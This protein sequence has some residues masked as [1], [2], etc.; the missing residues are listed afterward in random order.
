V[1]AKLTA[2]V[3]A[4]DRGESPAGDR[5]TVARFLD[6]WLAASASSLRPRTL[7]GYASHVAIYIK[8]MLGATPLAKLTPGH[9]QTML[10]ELERHGRPGNVER[11]PLSAQTVAHVRA[12]LRRALGQ[13]ERW[14][15]VTRNV[16]KLTDAPR[17]RRVDVHPLAGVE[18]R[19]FLDATRED[20]VWPLYVVAIATGMR[21]G[22][23]LG[24]R[25]SEVDLEAATLRVSATLQRLQGRPVLVEPKTS[26]S[27]R[28]IP[29]ARIAVDALRDQRRRQ[30]A[31]RLLAGSRWSDELGLV[32]TTSI[33]MPHRPD[34]VTHRFQDALHAAGLPRQRFHDLRHAAASLLLAH[35]VSAR[36]LMETLGHSTISVTMNT[37]AHVMPALQRD[38]ADRMDDALASN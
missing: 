26:R 17:I 4:A 13:A 8:P 33:G 15:Y 29:L 10:A 24:L 19:R 30:L 9:V 6:E 22:E 3:Q 21:Q 18:L 7:E 35:G 32:F 34:A 25:W 31:D 36:V 27:R 23:L 20:R 38:A 12:T 37:Y 14:G 1:R 5:L 2:G 16:A 11:R 28:T